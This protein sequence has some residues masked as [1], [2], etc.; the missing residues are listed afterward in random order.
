MIERE[1]YGDW[2]CPVTTCVNPAK[3]ALPNNFGTMSLLVL[4]L[5][6]PALAPRNV[7]LSCHVPL[8]TPEK[9]TNAA[10]TLDY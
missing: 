6:A 1:E 8:C 7:S 10:Q 2:L 4:V 5:L 3:L 9:M